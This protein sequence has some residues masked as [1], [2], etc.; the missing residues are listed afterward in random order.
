M[1]VRNDLLKRLEALER[2]ATLRTLP[3]LTLV[4]VT[5]WPDDDRDA[6][7]AAEARGDE[8]ALGVLIERYTGRKA[9]PVP[10]GYIGTVVVSLGPLCREDWLTARGGDEDE[11]AVIQRILQEDQDERERERQDQ[12]DA[13]KA[14]AEQ[15]PRAVWSYDAD[16]TPIF[17]DDPRLAHLFRN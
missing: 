13:A 11:D 3:P 4:N 17:D 15:R 7:W 5:A 9:E 1:T 12:I 6:Y 10:S 16:G 2:T 14:A 8:A